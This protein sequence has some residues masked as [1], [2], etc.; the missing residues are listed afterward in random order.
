MI[1]N[2]SIIPRYCNATSPKANCA[3]LVLSLIVTEMS[4]NE[5]YLHFSHNL[6]V[7]KHPKY[8]CVQYELKLRINLLCNCL[9]ERFINLSNT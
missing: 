2:T 5:E 6:D 3:H 9:C 8:L 7:S 1:L 4:V